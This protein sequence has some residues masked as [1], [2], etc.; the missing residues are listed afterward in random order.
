MNKQTSYF[1]LS[2]LFFVVFLLMELTDIYD[3]PVWFKAMLLILC[4]SFLFSGFASK[5][6]KTNDS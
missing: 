3:P 1:F 6:K 4:I 5:T 2:G